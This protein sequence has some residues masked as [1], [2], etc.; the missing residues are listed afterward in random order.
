MVKAK[1]ISISLTIPK[2]EQL[3]MKRIWPRF[4]NDQKVCQYMPL[5]HSE[6]IPPRNFFYKILHS[7]FR[8]KFDR[9]IRN[10]KEQRMQEMQQNNLVINA[11]KQVLNELEN[12]SIW[13][14]ISRSQI[15]KR[16]TPYK[17]TRGVRRQD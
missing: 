16:V 11:N 8:S 4:K 17:V 1:S 6:R 13:T 5:T 9:L 15:S 10:A 12:C 3:S 14:D 2:L 7:K